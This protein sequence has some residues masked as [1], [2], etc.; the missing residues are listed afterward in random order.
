[1]RLDTFALSLTGEAASDGSVAAGF[2][3]NFSLDPRNGFT[4]SRRTLAEGGMVHA[5]VF[6]DLNDNGVRDAGEPLEKGVLI[7]TGARQGERK[8]DA[9]GSVTVGGLTPYMPVP[10]GLDSTS[11]E[12]P[13]LV[14]KK[15]IQVVVPRP[16]VSADVQIALVGGGDIEGALIK[17][18]EQGFEGVDMELVDPSGKTVDTARTDFDGFFLFERVA[19]GRYTLRVSASSA[20]AAK[21]AR[22]LG[23]ELKVSPEKPIVRLGAI[24]A[25][26]PNRFASAEMPEPA[27]P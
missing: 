22:E 5:T 12:D 7:T 6:R 18:G 9:R 17:N 11:L 26:L 27:T 23:V 15:P 25:R 19:Y 1:M 21:I 4:L 16:G 14:P 24:H 13:M 20:A 3:L 10:V 2:N 8:T